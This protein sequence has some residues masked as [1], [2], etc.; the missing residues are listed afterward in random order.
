[1]KRILAPAYATGAYLAFLC[2][3][4]WAVG[5]LANLPAAPT[6]VDG[7]PRGSTPTSLVV[8]L[9][10]LLAF[11]VQHSV[12]ARPAV[13]RALSRLV[14]PSVERATYVLTTSLVLALLFWQWHPMPTTLW[15]VT[16]QPWTTALWVG[17]ALGWLVAVSSTFMV[18][19]LDFLGIRQANRH[20][21]AG[22]R[23]PE[24]R[25]RLLYR[26][27][28][29]PMM[30]GLLIA[31]WVTPRM[32][33]GHL[34]FAVAAAGYIALGVR[35][36][37]RDLRADLGPVYADYAARVRGFVPVAARRP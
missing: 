35:L 3:T 25:E 37:E 6:T 27:V 15:L 13:K 34:V 32:T 28:R 30:V 26:W 16:A 14:P 33:V 22:Y 4:L 20:G 24:C 8:D 11:A 31:F 18:D 36:E 12:L 2:V 10:L 17:Y 19:H 23:P 29:H 1:V 21:A 9:V 7:P 5:F